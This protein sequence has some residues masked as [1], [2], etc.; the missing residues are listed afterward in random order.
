MN[1]LC[2]LT[3]TTLTVLSCTCIIHRLVIGIVACQ[4]SGCAVCDTMIS[5]C[6]TC[7]EG[8]FPS[9]NTD[10]TTGMY[11]SDICTQYYGMVTC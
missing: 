7:E 4:V 10:C 2:T 11:S 3:I 6:D 8:Y 9:S 1:Y 5:Q